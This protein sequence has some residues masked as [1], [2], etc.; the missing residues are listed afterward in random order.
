MKKENKIFLLPVIILLLFLMSK[1]DLKASG[2]E[3]LCWV[4]YCFFVIL[5]ICILI[6]V[7]YYFIKKK[8]KFRQIVIINFVI[9]S[10]CGISILISSLFIG[11]NFQ[12]SNKDVI[13]ESKPLN[14][15]PNNYVYEYK[16]FF[17]RGNKK[18][19]CVAEICD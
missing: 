17:I 14:F 7:T 13:H 15:R 16:N 2:S 11:T 9:A 12:T 1:A 8:Y 4:Y 10:I 3:Y 19:K 6:S 18:I 5:T